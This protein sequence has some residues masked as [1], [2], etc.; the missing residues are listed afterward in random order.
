MF[1]S[2]LVNVPQVRADIDRVKAKRDNVPLANVFEALQVYL[3]SLYVN[4][5]NLFGR[6]Y[7]VIAQAERRSRARKEQILSLKT[8]NAQGDMVPL[9]SVM[10][11]HDSIGPDIVTHYNGYLAADIN[12]PGRAGH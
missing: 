1:S 2:Y 9:G 12:G 4:D 6:S 5:L 11:V 7:Q 3:G 8:R 10:T